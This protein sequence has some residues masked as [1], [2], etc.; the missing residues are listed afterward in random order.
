MERYTAQGGMRR[1][2][3]IVGSFIMG[4]LALEV[5]AIVTLS[6][7]SLLAHR[8]RV[9]AVFGESIAG[10]EVGAP[11]TFRGARIGRGRTD[12][13]AHRRSSSN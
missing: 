12:A 6:G 13:A 10:L 5:I 2:A 4:A 11:V 8:L 9:V 7:M 3:L 1:K